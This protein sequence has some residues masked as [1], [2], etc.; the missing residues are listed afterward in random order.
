MLRLIRSSLFMHLCTERP[1][2]FSRASTVPSHL[3]QLLESPNSNICGRSAS[4]A[5]PFGKVICQTRSKTQRRGAA[6]T[7]QQRGCEVGRQRRD[8][9][10]H[11]TTGQPALL[12]RALT[13]AMKRICTMAHLKTGVTVRS[14]RWKSLS[15]PSLTPNPNNANFI[16]Q[17]S[18]PYRPSLV[19]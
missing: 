12:R 18:L 2:P 9:L 16:L 13:S 10:P 11:R 3:H 6:R 17:F 8:L 5:F 7:L 14:C 15:N 1:K 4:D 19:G